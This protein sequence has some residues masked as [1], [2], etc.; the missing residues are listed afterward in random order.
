M[1][2]TFFATLNPMLVLFFS[3]AVGFV[4]KVTKILPDDAGKTIAKLETWVFAPALSFSTMAANCTVKSL[5]THATNILFSCFVISL[6]IL[7]AIPLSKMF[8]KQ[9]SAE[10]GIYKYALTFANFGYMADPIVLAIFGDEALAYYKMFTLPASIMVYTWGISVL[11]PGVANRGSFL[12]KTMNAPTIALLLGIVAGLTGLGSHMPTFI[13]SS[14]NSLKAC[15]GPV[16]M[17]LAGV[18][19]ANYSLRAMLKNKKLY[20]ASV[21][22]LIVIPAVLVFCVFGA[23]ELVNLIFSLEINNMVVYLAFFFSAMPL[24]LNTVVFPE[25]YGGNPEIGAGMALIS[26]TLCVVTIP[27]LFTLMTAL[28]GAFPL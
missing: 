20:I 7:I 23:K 9:P 4:L 14:L 26:H 18:T 10:R 13:A 1:F 28:F 27:V 22:R 19:V 8:V 15:M 6:S 12:K 25:A 16:A 5:S 11:T 17:I 24:G 3:I 2:E 21:L